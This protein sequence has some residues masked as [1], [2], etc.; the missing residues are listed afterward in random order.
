MGSKLKDR[1]VRR[2]SFNHVQAKNKWGRQSDDPKTHNAKKQ[3]LEE[4]E[5]DESFDDDFDDVDC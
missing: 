2:P 5:Y 3:R 4:I 1:Q